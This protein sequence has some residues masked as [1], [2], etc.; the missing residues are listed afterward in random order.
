MKRAVSILLVFLC[1]LCLPSASAAT[2]EH[3]AEVMT[4]FQGF[5]SGLD[6]RYAFNEQALVAAQAYA[7]APGE[8]TLSQAKEV[9]AAAIAGIAGLPLPSS[10]ISQDA[11]AELEIMGQAEE[12]FAPFDAEPS[13]RLS[14]IQTMQTL[15]SLLISHASQPEVIGQVAELNLEMLTRDR[16]IEYLCLNEFVNAF[17]SEGTKAFREEFLP[18][19]A[20]FGKDNL[21]WGADNAVLEAMAEELFTQYEGLLSQYELLIGKMYANLMNAR[22]DT[23]KL[24]AEQGYTQEQIDAMLG[25]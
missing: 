8:E 25:E 22:A 9:C 13:Y 15:A 4:A 6:Q 5:L 16:K 12:F 21:G 1:F 23:A 14:D 11:Q 2:R 17:S 18:T 3:E 24:M 10:A 19:L 20:V 7:Q